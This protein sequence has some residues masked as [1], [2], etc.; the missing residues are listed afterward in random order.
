MRTPNGMDPRPMS[1]VFTDLRKHVD[2]GCTP[3]EAADL[4]IRTLTVDDLAM[5][6][7][8]LLVH[9]AHREQ[10]NFDR[11]VEQDVDLR[12]DLGADPIRVRRLLSTTTFALPSGEF[13]PWLDA[14]ADQHRLRASWQRGRAASCVDDA[15]RHES[16]A[17][18]IE[19]AGVSCLRDLDTIAVSA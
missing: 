15:E 5:F 16:A 1:S 12:L 4:V 11:H 8:P 13:V 7:R 18:A 10:R 19:T 3:E 14:T 17:V 2:N 9:Q 6:V